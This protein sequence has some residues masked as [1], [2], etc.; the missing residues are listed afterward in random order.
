MELVLRLVRPF[1]SPLEQAVQ[2]SQAKPQ[3][4]QMN[5]ADAARYF[6]IPPSKLYAAIRSGHLN[7]NKV[8]HNVLVFDTEVQDL[9]ELVR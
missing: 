3:P 9:L 6:K 5:V 4:V 7:A 2:D 1:K 8:G